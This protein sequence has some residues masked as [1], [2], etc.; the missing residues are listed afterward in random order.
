MNPED[1]K[2]LSKQLF[3]LA[4]KFK[5]IELS[6]ET[7]KEVD[8]VVTEMENIFDVAKQKNLNIEKN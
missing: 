8:K 4:D 3:D 6:P 1:R 5:N 2:K 7:T